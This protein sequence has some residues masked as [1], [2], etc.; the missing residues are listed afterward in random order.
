LLTT[1]KGGPHKL[2]GIGVGFYPPFLDD[3]KID[4]ILAIDHEAA[5]EMRNT[6][7]TRHGIFCGI[8]TSLNVVEAI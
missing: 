6:L 7:A 4:D 3:Q 2:E 1:G 5:V 8:S